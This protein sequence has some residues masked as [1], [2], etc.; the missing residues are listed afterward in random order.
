M[1]GRRFKLEMTFAGTALVLGCQQPVHPAAGATLVLQSMVDRAVTDNELIN[2]AVLFVDAPRLGLRWE[3]AAG[4]AGP[5]APMTALHPVRIASNTKTYVAAAVLRLAE[6]GR[7]D[8]DDAIAAHLPD[9]I[10]ALLIGDGY[11]PEQM[12][13]R[14]LLTHTSGLYDHSDSQK[15]GDAIMADPQHRWTRTEQVEAAM[16]WG[17]PWGA[18]GE[19]Y[20]YCDTG[21]VLLGAI[22][23]QVSGQPLAAAVRDLLHFDELGLAAT[24]WED[25][26][27]PPDG[28]P[29]RAHQFID[30]TDTFAFDPSFDLYGGGGL[31]ATVADMARF[32][33]ALF[34]GGVFSDPATGDLMLTTVDGAAA[35]PDA[36]DSALAPGAYRMGVWVVEID[37]VTAY[38][39]SGFWGTAAVF[40]PELD[41]AVAATVNQNKAKEA[42]WDMVGEAIS[43]VREAQNS[44]SL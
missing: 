26:E 11:R 31:V 8:V 15:Y 9:E 29:D 37:G 7:L 6:E 33:R 1:V 25:L 35:R 18:P 24:W 27:P 13:V 30:S 12:T 38:A 36:D 40:V 22:I 28:V 10:V 42:L 21:Y 41:L 16:A 2:G 17:Q 43:I 3:G 23:E 34:S 44:A 32:D 4:I 14:H 39:H 5:G 20:T 19:I